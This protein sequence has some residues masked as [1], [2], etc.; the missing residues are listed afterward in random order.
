MNRESRIFV[1]GHRGMVGSALV[2]ALQAMGFGN[3]ITRSRSNLDLID[4]AAVNDFFRSEK[5]DVVFMAAA[6]VGGIFANDTFRADFI[7]QNLIVECNVIHAAYSAG[8]EN[9]LFLAGSCIYPKNC[10]QPM[11]EEY[12]FNLLVII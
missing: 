7:Y 2:R 12:F 11:K 10:P 9:I 3:I 6:K 5:I 1:A 4:Q 8:V